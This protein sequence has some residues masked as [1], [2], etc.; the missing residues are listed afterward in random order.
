MHTPANYR[1]RETN[2]NI[3]LRHTFLQEKSAEFVQRCGPPWS[4]QVGPRPLSFTGL[5]HRLF[6]HLEGH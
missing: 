6:L 3:I 4:D 1:I 2:Q 5:D